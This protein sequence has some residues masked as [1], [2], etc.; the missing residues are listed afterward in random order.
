MA[1]QPRVGWAPPAK[2]VK[3]A[4][5]F[6]RAPPGRG[7]N[8][9]TVPQHSQSFAAPAP[10]IRIHF[11]GVANLIAAITLRPPTARGRVLD[12]RET[13]P[14]NLSETP[15]QNLGSCIHRVRPGLTAPRQKWFHNDRFRARSTSNDEFFPVRFGPWR[16]PTRSIH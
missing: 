5:V 4:H 2:L 8:S 10:G 15:F 16:A 3:Q 6:R 9:K 1:Q 14:A 12:A 11:P 13:E 7:R